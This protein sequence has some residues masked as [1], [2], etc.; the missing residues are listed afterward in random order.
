M[1]SVLAQQTAEVVEFN[2]PAIDWHAFAPELVV[3][4]GFFGP[5][6]PLISEQLQGEIG[7]R[8]FL[9]EARS[10]RIV[11]SALGADAGLIGAAE[12]A[13]DPLVDNPLMVR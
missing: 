2:R 13:F 3:L 12:L 5:I 8:V 4:G 9:G 1:L 10:V 11:A 7:T 6:L